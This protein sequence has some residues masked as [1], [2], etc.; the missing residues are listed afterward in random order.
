MKK[1]ME[2]RKMKTRNNNIRDAQV[3]QSRP[4]QAEIVGFNSLAFH[5]SN[6]EGD[7]L[8]VLLGFEINKVFKGCV[9]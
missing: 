3:C 6:F 2:T 9:L 5:Q 1:F 8:I 4:N 7:S